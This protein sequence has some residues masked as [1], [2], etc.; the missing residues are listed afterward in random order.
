VLGDEGYRVTSLPDLVD[1]PAA[2]LRLAPD[3]IVLDLVFDREER[4]LP[5]LRQ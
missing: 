3:L 2:V 4:G 5:F 1:D